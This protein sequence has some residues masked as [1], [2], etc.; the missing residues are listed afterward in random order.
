MFQLLFSPLSG[1]SRRNG[2]LFFIRVMNCRLLMVVLVKF[3]V[4]LR[5]IVLKMI[6]LF[7]VHL[8]LFLRLEVRVLI[9]FV[10]IMPLILIVG[11]ILLLKIKLLIVFLVLVKFVT[12]K[13]INL[14]VLVFQ[15]NVL[16]RRLKVKK[17]L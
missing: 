2:I 16:M 13:L 1:V 5:Q 15:K 12:R 3:S 17:F 4:K 14:L 11:G 9:L 8:L 6:S 7:F 10:L